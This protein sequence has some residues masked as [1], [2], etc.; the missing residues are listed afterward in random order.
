[1]I[2][3][4]NADAEW[5]QWFDPRKA[6]SITQHVVLPPEPAC[7]VICSWR[8]AVGHC[9]H[10]VICKNN[11]RAAHETMHEYLQQ[12]NRAHTLQLTIE[13]LDEDVSTRLCAHRGC[14]DHARDRSR[15][16]RSQTL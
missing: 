7:D 14:F 5:L 9:T 10:G 16:L 3:A 1:M 4:H 6:L 13:H 12:H 2:G 11:G 15:R 8:R